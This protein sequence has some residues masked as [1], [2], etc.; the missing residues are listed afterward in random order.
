MRHLCRDLLTLPTASCPGT[1]MYA[2]AMF[3]IQCGG[4]GMVG[5]T[6]FNVLGSGSLLG[7]GISGSINTGLGTYEVQLPTASY[8]VSNAD[9]NRILALKSIVN[10]LA[11]SGLFR[12]TGVDTA[13]NGV[14]IDY[15]SAAAPPSELYLAWRVF[16][17]EVVFSQLWRTGSNG[18]IG[19]YGSYSPTTSS[20]ASASRIILRSPDV[21]S[22]EVRMCLESAVDVSGSV[23]SG[24]SIAPG[25]GGNGTGDFVN[26]TN[27]GESTGKV[28]HLHAAAFYN[29]TSSNY[30]GMVV[31]LSPSSNISGSLWTKGQWRISMMVDDVSG[32]CGIV[33]KNVS[34]PISHINSGSGWC[35][36]GLTEDET[37]FPTSN[38]LG[39][40]TVNVTRLFVVGSSNPQSNLTWRS[41]FHADNN[42]QTVG[43]SKYGYPVAGVLSLY[44]DISNPEDHVRYLTSSA[45]TPWLSETELLDA[46]VLLGTVDVTNSATASPSLWPMQPRRL[47]RLPMFLQGRAN[48]TQWAVTGD[49]NWY[50]TQDGIFMSWGGPVPTGNPSVSSVNTEIGSIE[51]QQGLV[52]HGAFLPGS[53]PPLPPEVPNVSDIDSTRFRKTYS[54]F[55]QV[56]VNVGTIRGGSNPSK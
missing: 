49:G 26:L 51:L 9:V 25:Y 31:G 14:T 56:P 46:E 13:N 36:F 11:N 55:R 37:E 8:V 5:Q 2:L 4:F 34:L 41:Q 24:F 21:S 12:I 18:L 42:I 10:P 50:H 39:N 40:A 22:W 7:T 35:V 44:S 32:T 29:T 48:Y 52:M 19:G 3:L 20:V 38:N 30:Q 43:W 17:N 28:L 53:D 54:Y 47:G 33:N 16:E 15:R 6:N 27:A 1:N 45:D 23:P